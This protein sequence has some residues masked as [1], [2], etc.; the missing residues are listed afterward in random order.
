MHFNAFHM[1]S[2]WLCAL[3]SAE[4]SVAV[5]QT[6][7]TWERIS[8]EKQHKMNALIQERS[9]KTKRKRQQVGDNK[10]LNFCK[11]QQHDFKTL[12]NLETKEENHL[13]QH[14]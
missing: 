7:E 11:Q 13:Q 5:N 4:Y 2:P 1:I 6:A 3:I 14:N 12:T 9:I 10:G 8:E